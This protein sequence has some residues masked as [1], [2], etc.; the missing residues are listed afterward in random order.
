MAP[1]AM[2]LVVK[3]LGLATSLPVI[4]AEDLGLMPVAVV[5]SLA[6]VVVENVTMEVSWS[7]I[8]KES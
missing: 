4:A 5:V 6:A 8:A 7:V 2:I 3:R 1:L